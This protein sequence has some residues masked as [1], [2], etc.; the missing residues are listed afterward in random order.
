M[1][2]VIMSISLIVKTIN[3]SGVGTNC[4]VGCCHAYILLPSGIINDDDDD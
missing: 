2:L 1:I 4:G 3:F